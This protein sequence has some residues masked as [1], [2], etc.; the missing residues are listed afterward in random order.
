MLFVAAS[1]GGALLVEPV[2]RAAESPDS[3]V[4]VRISVDDSFS[5]SAPGESTLG[6]WERGSG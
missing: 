4:L 5:V 1:A 6:V 3:T 2:S